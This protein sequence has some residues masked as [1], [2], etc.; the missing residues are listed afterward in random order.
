MTTSGSKLEF[1]EPGSEGETAGYLTY[2]R[3]KSRYGL[4]MEEEGIPIFLG[5]TACALWTCRSPPRRCSPRCAG[6]PAPPHGSD[7]P[8]PD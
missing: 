6:E 2:K 8:Q 4:Y 1:R 3:V 5:C 7:L